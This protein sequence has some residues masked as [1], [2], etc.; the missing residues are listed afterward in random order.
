[1]GEI[2]SALEIALEKAEKIG[3]ASKE[4]LRA[5]ECRE[6]GQRLA[7]RYLNEADFDLAGEIARLSPEEKIPVLRGLVEVL[8]RNL[9]LP[10]DEYALKEVR[11]ALS[12]L[13]VV[14]S[15]F[16]EVRNLTREIDR[17]LSQYLNHREALYQQLKQQ[18]EA[19][20]SDVEKALSDQMGVKVKVDVEMQPQFQEEWRKLR[21]QLDPQY[22]QQLDYLKG[23][24]EKALGT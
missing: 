2:R 16:P 18:F 9:V 19:Q 10:R 20:L 1:M 22:Q 7:A 15:A 4:E 24:F 14:F 5:Q 12:G 13:E 21:D 3:K 23:I 11:R 17:L 8:V 6:K